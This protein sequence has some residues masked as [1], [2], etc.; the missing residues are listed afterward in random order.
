MIHRTEAVVLRVAPFSKTSHVV[1]WLT[2]SHG[3]IATVVKGAQRPKS[4]LLGQYDLFY[5]CELLFY[6]RRGGG[7]HVMRE[8]SPLATRTSFRTNW[9]ACACAS[10]LCDLILRISPSDTEQ[11]ELYSI[12]TAALDLLGSGEITQQFLLWIELKVLRV[13]GVSPRL[14]HCLRCASEL[15]GRKRS[16]M[17]FSLPGGGILCADCQR[18][19]HGRAAPIQPDVLA[20]MQKWQSSD[21]SHIVRKIRCTKEQ[22]TGISSIIGSFLDYHLDIPPHN[23]DIA[24]L[25]TRMDLKQGHKLRSENKA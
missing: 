3:K 6:E 2:P 15:T 4:W 9:R 23:R 1:T 13:L 14:S 20:I 11:A 21:K 17:L 22:L 25:L 5:T 24:L 7:L 19:H 16:G 10:Y 18:D 12:F 8:C